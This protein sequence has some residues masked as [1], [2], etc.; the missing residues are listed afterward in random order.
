MGFTTKSK[1][2]LQYFGKIRIF[3]CPKKKQFESKCAN[4]YM[5]LEIIIVAYELIMKVA[6]TIV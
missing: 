4:S 2:Q 1:F 3:C 6:T 5:E